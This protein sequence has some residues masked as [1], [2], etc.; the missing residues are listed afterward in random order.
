MGPALYG[1]AV[2][3]EGGNLHCGSSTVEAK[4]RRGAW[5]RGVPS[6]GISPAPPAGGHGGRQQCESGQPGTQRRRAAG[7]RAVT[8][9]APLRGTSAVAES[10]V[11]R[12]ANGGVPD[13]LR[14]LVLARVEAQLLDARLDPGD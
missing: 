14:L 13:R 11:G 8:A 10:T 9:R 6:P 12:E 3:K 7:R 4:H 2:Y 1:N 5:S